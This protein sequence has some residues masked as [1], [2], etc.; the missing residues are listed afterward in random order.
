M[1]WLAIYIALAVGVLIG[2]GLAA[3]LE[4]GAR[5]YERSE[6]EAHYQKLL[7]RRAMKKTLGK[8]IGKLTGIQ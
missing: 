8:R 2:F 7:A 5:E 3:L 4:M 1:S 6:L